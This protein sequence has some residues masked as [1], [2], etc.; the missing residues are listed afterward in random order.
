[1]IC[2]QTIGGRLIHR[3]IAATTVDWFA[4]WMMHDTDRVIIQIRIQKLTDSWGWASQRIDTEQREK[5]YLI[6]LDQRQAL[7]SFVQTLI[8]ELMH[9]RQYERGSWIGDGEAEAESSEV[10][11]DAIWLSGLI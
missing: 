5:I 6:A 8:H 10:L 11:A 7:R 2:T 9:I 3:D 4:K 1:M